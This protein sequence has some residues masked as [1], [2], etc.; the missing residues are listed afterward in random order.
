LIPNINQITHKYFN[1]NNICQYKFKFV[2]EKGRMHNEKVRTGA[3][4][5]SPVMRECTTKK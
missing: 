3:V 4:P 1:V 2:E 5:L